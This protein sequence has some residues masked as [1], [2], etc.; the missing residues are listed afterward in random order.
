MFYHLV[1]HVSSSVQ[2]KDMCDVPQQFLATN[3]SN[4]KTSNR[5][6]KKYIPKKNKKKEKTNTSRRRRA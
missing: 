1:Y 3:R 2:I 4:Q 6:N 5:K